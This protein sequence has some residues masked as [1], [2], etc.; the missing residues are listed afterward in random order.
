MTL[1]RGRKCVS[2]YLRQPVYQLPVASHPLRK[3][4][5]SLVGEFSEFGTGKL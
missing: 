3:R 2:K 1:K 5:K 4:E